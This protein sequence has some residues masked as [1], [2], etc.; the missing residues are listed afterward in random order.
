MTES[1]I[2]FSSYQGPR[3]FVSCSVG[4]ASCAINP[5]GSPTPTTAAPAKN[6]NFFS[7]SRRVI[8]LPFIVSLLVFLSCDYYSSWEGVMASN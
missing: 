2:R 1:P 7:S 4:S 3:F 5:R 8:P 6:P